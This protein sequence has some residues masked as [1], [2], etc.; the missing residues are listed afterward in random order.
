MKRSVSSSSSSSGREAR[1][2]SLTVEQMVEDPVSELALAHWSEHNHN[3]NQAL[4][5]PL[6]RQLFVE[7][8]SAAD[9]RRVAL[10]E[11]SR[12]LEE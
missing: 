9:V 11:T 12:Y 2:S 4:S 5:E 7:V 10:L 6:L 8:L 3:H 1:S